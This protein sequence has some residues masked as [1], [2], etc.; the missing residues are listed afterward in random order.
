MFLTVPWL[1]S[2]CL[3]GGHPVN[4]SVSTSGKSRK[5]TMSDKTS[6]GSPCRYMEV[7]KCFLSTKKATCDLG[8]VAGQNKIVDK[9]KSL[10]ST[11]DF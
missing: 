2:R 9:G 10:G 5:R 4:T 7:A 8:R 1:H 3:K 11:N 6:T